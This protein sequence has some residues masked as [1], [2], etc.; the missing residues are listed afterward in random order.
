MHSIYV[1]AEPSLPVTA[2][3]VKKSSERWQKQQQRFQPEELFSTSVKH[4]TVVDAGLFFNLPF[5]SVLRQQRAVQLIL[6]F[7]FSARDSDNAPPFAELLASEQ[8]ARANGIRF[9]PIADLIERN[10]SRDRE[11]REFYVFKDEADARCPV[12]IFLPLVCNQ[13]KSYT[14]P[15]T[16]L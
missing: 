3:D 2:G 6:C 11:P 1:C 15:G 4:M 9:P 13:F 12:I 14:K 7:D 10:Y 8:W 16:E 5:P